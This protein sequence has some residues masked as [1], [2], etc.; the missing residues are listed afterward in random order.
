M[1]T[2]LPTSIDTEESFGTASL[3]TAITVRE[4]IASE[5]G[6]GIASVL[7]TL[8]GTIYY[9][10][11]RGVLRNDWVIKPSI[12]R[13]AAIGGGSRSTASFTL[14]T[15][16][17]LAAYRPNTG[18]DVT[19]YEFVG[20]QFH[21]FFGG[22]IETLE[23]QRYGTVPYFSVQVQCSDYGV[24]CDR[25]IVGKFYTLFLGGVAAIA[26]ADV[27]RNFLDGTGIWFDDTA[28]M[29][30]PTT[31]LGEMLFE[32][33]SV[34]ETLNSICGKIDCDW[35]VDYNKELL[36]F[37]RGSGYA[38]APYSVTDAT[39]NALLGIRVRRTYTE[40]FN[41]IGVRP[42]IA[43]INYWTDSFI[44]SETQNHAGG[45]WAFV[46]TYPFEGSTP[47]VFVDGV[48]QVVA[49]IDEIN[50]VPD[51][52]FY[53]NGQLFLGREGTVVAGSDVQIL[54]PS[55]LPYIF[56]AEDA[57]DIAIRGK[58]ERVESVEGVFDV[59]ALQE[60]ANGLL[61]RSVADSVELEFSS[62][63]PFWEPGQ[64]LTVDLTLPAVSASMVIESVDSE[65]LPNGRACRHNIKTSSLPPVNRADNFFG[66]LIEKANRPGPV[67]TQNIRFTLAETIEGLTN[68]GLA[69]GAP[70]ALAVVER[71]GI[72][73]DMRL[74][75]RS[76]DLLG[77]APVTPTEVDVFLNGISVFNAEHPPILYP[78]GHVG[79]VQVF[80][81]ATNPLYVNRGDVLT[82]EVLQAG[83]LP[84]E[85][86]LSDG[87]LEIVI[88]N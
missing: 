2:I 20:G 62:L 82:F 36:V 85:A 32:F 65:E 79:D 37:P 63:S 17:G 31:V 57:A 60:V 1:P 23:E 40:R 53:Y 83:S 34:T 84:G 9:T 68:T 73:R 80:L 72:M 41:R 39:L 78:A 56:W 76:I 51:W 22:V 11:I 77:Q 6:F 48:Q 66:K 44:A 18:D 50:A 29:S 5:E 24:I 43:T 38:P 71:D 54:Y 16:P 4:G 12:R 88:L 61:A 13:N 10:Y 33:V 21:V 19:I 64:L 69:V 30:L 49:H 81:F 35:R 26:I 45:W 58:V 8:Q 14:T 7:N 67:I 42:S 25:R 52:T 74:R 55:P 28:A 75:F 15:K 87:V 46:T 70:M 27:V 47:V 86:V 59:G 3:P